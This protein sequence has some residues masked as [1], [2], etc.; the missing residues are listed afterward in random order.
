MDWNVS[1]RDHE[2]SPREVATYGCNYN[3]FIIA[4]S[5]AGADRDRNL[6]IDL[7]AIKQAGAAMARVHFL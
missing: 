7:E 1:D 6:A 4:S 3:L 5:S 2:A